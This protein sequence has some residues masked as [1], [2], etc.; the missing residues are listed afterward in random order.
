L[1]TFI[2]SVRQVSSRRT[3][4]PSWISISCSPPLSLSRC[5]KLEELCY[6]AR[7]RLHHS[8]P[9]PWSHCHGTRHR[10][11]RDR[12]IPRPSAVPLKTVVPPTHQPPWQYEFFRSPSC[13]CRE[14]HVFHYL[15][16][17]R[18]KLARSG[19]V[20]LASPSGYDMVYLQ[21]APRAARCLTLDEFLKP[22]LPQQPE[23]Q[24][25]AD[26]LAQP[27]NR[28]CGPGEC[29]EPGAQRKSEARACSQALLHSHLQSLPRHYAVHLVIASCF[30]SR[31]PVDTD[32]LLL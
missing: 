6:D 29:A 2:S 18:L 32:R 26:A 23:S 24:H 13:L 30:V 1:N 15:D 5:R 27:A 17:P 11:P 20:A 16:D 25:P 8:R 19:P 31:S 22:T 21:R 10:H 4:Y 12:Q 3:D 28:C 7:H 14:V 9:A